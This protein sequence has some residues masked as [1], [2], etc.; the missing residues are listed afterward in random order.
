MPHP[1][2][3]QEPDC[4]ANMV[5]D[6]GTKDHCSDVPRPPIS[7]PP[8][9]R[10]K[11]TSFLQKAERI[12]RNPRFE[13]LSM[14]MIFGSA[15]HIG[16]QTD[17][18]ARHMLS[19]PPGVFRAFDFGFLTFFVV[20]LLLRLAA[21]RSRYF[22][23]WGWGWN[24]LDLILIMIQVLEEV[25]QAANPDQGNGLSSSLLRIIRVLRAVRVVRVV[26]AM[27]FAEELRLLVNCVAHSAKSFHWA[28]AL[29]ALMVYVFAVHITQ[30]TLMERLED[31][32]QN[33]AR[34]G[35]GHRDDLG[36]WFG[37]VPLS[38]LSLFQGLTGGVDWNE[39]I[40]P[41]IGISP[42]WGIVFVAYQAFALIAVMNVVTGTF[43]QQAMER[44]QHMNEVRKVAQAS[45]VFKV[46]DVNREGYIT[47]DVIEK[48]METAAVRGFFESIDLDL[49][50]A[51]CLF[52]MLDA[53]NSGK[54]DFE[55]FLSGCMRLQG[56][57]KAIDMVMFMREMKEHLQVIAA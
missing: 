19:Q 26:H 21:Y 22:Y 53:D 55:E 43:V 48:N 10:T 12:V 44:A 6:L 14:A 39:L 2:A 28:A 30:I 32:A 8:V 46:L 38:V 15:V 4:D 27:H 25:V 47:F 17:H 52:E 11:Q 35:W 1:L 7:H 5:P 41:L 9:A 3:P 45:N 54:L 50:E 18:M 37:S 40:L 16:W 29:I 34:D 31:S 42:W 51:R 24:V 23:M 33:G 57:A 56:P 36:R 49:S 20:E 13:F